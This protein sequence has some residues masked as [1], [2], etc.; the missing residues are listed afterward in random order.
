MGLVF[1][2]CLNVDFVS[3][4]IVVQTATYPNDI[5][6]ERF[7]VRCAYTAIPV[8]SI[9]RLNDVRVKGVLHV[10]LRVR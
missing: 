3:Y 6:F 2:K 9:V 8:K 7:F 4:K 10:R 5:T 1:S